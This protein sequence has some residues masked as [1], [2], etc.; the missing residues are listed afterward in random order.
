MLLLLCGK[1]ASRLD[2]APV[3]AKRVPDT[4]PVH[5]CILLYI[6]DHLG[7]S[8]GELFFFRRKIIERVSMHRQPT[9][10]HQH[11]AHRHI[12]FRKFSALCAHLFFTDLRIKCIPA[13][14]AEIFQ[15]LR[16]IPFLSQTDSVILCRPGHTRMNRFLQTVRLRICINRLVQFA[17]SA[18]AGAHSENKRILSSRLHLGLKLF[19]RH[20]KQ[21]KVSVSQ[22]A[23]NRL[24]QLRDF[25]KVID[26]CRSCP[27]VV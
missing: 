10:I 18:L 15:H 5:L 8:V 24:C 2:S 22:L 4:K 3:A 16:D 27:P 17:D 25:R 23:V 14:P 7:E 1:A 13:A 19:S 20:W 26:K 12:F 9:V 6:T 11:P 21:E